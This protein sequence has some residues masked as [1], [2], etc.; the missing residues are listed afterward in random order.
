M[1]DMK[2]REPLIITNL[3]KGSVV[4]ALDKLLS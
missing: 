1:R 4:S 2:P 3:N